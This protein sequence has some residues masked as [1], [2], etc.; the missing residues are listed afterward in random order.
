M[1]AVRT[2]RT[3]A[4]L[5]Q[6]E[7]ASMAG[8]SQPTIAAYEAGRKSPSVATL[9]RLADA[10]GMEMNAAFHPPM[11]REERRSLHLHGAIASRLMRDPEAIL[12]TARRNLDLMRARHPAAESLLREW[13][14]L[15]G[16]PVRELASALVDSSPRGR[17]LRQATPF[18]GVLSASERAEVYREFAAKEAG[19]D[20]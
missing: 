19:R 14:V 13:E 9:R 10:A 12:R 16:R 15:L 5:T 1:N 18:A 2:L 4:G 17:E 20:T 3:L 8:T 11:T 7:L 6:A